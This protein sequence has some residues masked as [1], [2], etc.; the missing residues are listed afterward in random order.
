MRVLILAGG[1]LMST[2]ASASAQQRAESRALDAAFGTVAAHLLSSA[3][4]MPEIQYSTRAWRDGRTFLQL[5]AHVADGN[6]YYCQHA[7]GNRVEWSDP[8]EKTTETK[9]D[10]VQA[11]RESIT[12]C[13]QAYHAPGASFESLLENIAHNNLHYGNAI[14]YLRQAGIVPPSSR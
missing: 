5:I 13:R 4:L 12:A 1:F 7:R 8:L 6:N 9:A 10:A 11:L 14:V 3:E 2:M